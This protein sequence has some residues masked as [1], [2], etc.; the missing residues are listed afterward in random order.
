MTTRP[1]AV[2]DLDGTLA[3]TG[4]RQHLLRQTPRD[5]RAFFAAATE[6]PP[7]C[8]KGMGGAPTPP[9]GWPWRCAAPRTARSSI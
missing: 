8:L 1:L 5:W 3:D 4:H 7:P 6:D 9:R 2:F